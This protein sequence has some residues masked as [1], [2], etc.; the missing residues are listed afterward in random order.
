MRIGK[1]EKIKIKKAKIGFLGPEGT[2]SWAAVKKIFPRTTRLCPF[3]SIRDV[4]EAVSQEEIN[5]G[6]I[7]TENTVG[8][9]VSET[10]YSLIDH[11]IFVIGSFKI[12]IHHFLASKAQSLNQ[13]KIIKSHPQALSQCK[14]WLDLNLPEATREATPS[15]I[16]PIFEDLSE[17]IGFI[18]P[19]LF[20]KKFKLNI[21]AKNIEDDHE[22]FTRFFIIS[23]GLKKNKLGLKAKN[24]LL[25]L[26]VYDRIGI[27]RDILNIFARRNINLSSLHSIPASFSAWD[28]LFFLELEKSYFDKDFKSILK[29]LEEYC[30]FIRVIGMAKKE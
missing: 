16:A 9:L 27:L 10:I 26:A 29:D 12:P 28:Y 18:I 2:F 6:V 22:N 20:A 21:L 7:P 4:F 5:F 1:I 25:F 15:T 17:N 19:Y 13:I 14:K 3:S 30:P 11:P 23:Q 24:T 8:G